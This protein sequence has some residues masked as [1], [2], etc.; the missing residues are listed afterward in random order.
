MM[1]V[2]LD[3]VLDNVKL[4][5]FLFLTYLVM[6][7]MEHHTGEKLQK[8][9]RSAGKS[10]PDSAGRFDGGSGPFRRALQTVLQ[11]PDV[12]LETP[13]YAQ[14]P[15]CPSNRVGALPLGAPECSQ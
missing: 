4:L 7:W 15:S 1:D 11:Y 2:L 3:T 5:P 10:S 13:E 14:R 12:L 6:E 9:I 8:G